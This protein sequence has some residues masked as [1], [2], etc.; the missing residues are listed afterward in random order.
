MPSSSVARSFFHAGL[1]AKAEQVTREILT[2]D[3]RHIGARHLLANL[4]AK[5]GKH[6]EA[7]SEE[8]AV[9]KIRPYY[10]PALNNLGSYYLE[11]SEFAA[12]IQVY[13]RGLEVDPN[14]ILLRRNLTVAYLRSGRYEEALDQAQLSTQFLP[15][16]GLGHYYL[17]QAYAGKGMVAEARK[18]FKKSRELQPG[19][20]TPAL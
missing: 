8:L 17:G 6:R 5:E 18:A 15:E 10:L 7:I 1:S 3:S 11:M 2:R 12:A 16:N 9:L 19:L 13:H 14:L 4:L 20:N